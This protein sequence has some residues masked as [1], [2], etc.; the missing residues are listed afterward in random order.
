MK[1]SEYEYKGKKLKVF[2]FDDEDNDLDFVVEAY[3]Y[4]DDLKVAFN[5]RKGL[6]IQETFDS[7][8][9]AIKKCNELLGKY[10]VIY[11]LIV[12]KHINAN[13]L[14]PEP[15]KVYFKFYGE[16]TGKSYFMYIILN[17]KNTV[18]DV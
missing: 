4:E 3:E 10:E 9:E 5:E 13:E 17:D 12:P 7:F 8:T 14:L 11:F 6:H 16:L 2:V 15:D 1:E 18:E